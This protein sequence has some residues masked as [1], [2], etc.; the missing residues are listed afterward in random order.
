MSYS[1]KTMTGRPLAAIAVTAIAMAFG[2]PAQANEAHHPV[3]DAAVLQTAPATPATPAMPGGMG[4]PDM[5]MDMGRMGA[6]PGQA[7]M[8]GCD[9]SRMMPMMM[10]MMMGSGS[11]M[12][13]G[14]PGAMGGGLMMGSGHVEGR[15]AFLKAE[16]GITD[17]QK[18]QWDAFAD[19]L[20]SVGKPPT[21]MA[22]TMAETMTKSDTGTTWADRL[23]MRTTTMTARIDALKALEAAA[24]PLFGVL[25]D[26]QKT[27]ADRLLAGPMGPMGSM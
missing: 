17:A 18:A 27:T 26:S 5:G 22:A 11:P 10:R 23:A 19:A 15:I 14:E 16:I 25:T 9:M 1:T 7:G 8:M 21:T 12:D 20:R 24:K 4:E 13:S 6:G 2:A 3:G